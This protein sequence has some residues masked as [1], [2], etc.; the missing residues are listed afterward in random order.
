MQRKEAGGK[1]HNKYMP[2]DKDIEERSGTSG[3]KEK[4]NSG[5]EKEWQIGA[6]FPDLPKNITPSDSGEETKERGN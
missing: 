3:T 6:V 4:N 2:K 1:A 5:E